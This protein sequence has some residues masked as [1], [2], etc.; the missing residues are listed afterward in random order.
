MILTDIYLILTE[1]LDHGN[2]AETLV[3]LNI[4]S[5][6]WVNWLAC[7]DGLYFKLR[8]PQVPFYLV[9]AFC[10]PKSWSSGV[11]PSKQQNTVSSPSVVCLEIWDPLLPRPSI[12]IY[13]SFLFII[14][15][16]GKTQKN[17]ERGTSENVRLGTV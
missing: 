4:V 5:T 12:C 14:G 7:T 3:R 17:Y 13:N 8:F 16:N 6:H 9:V 11:K 1:H 2:L 10:S 15:R